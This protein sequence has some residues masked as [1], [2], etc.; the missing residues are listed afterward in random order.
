MILPIQMLLNRSLMLKKISTAL[1]RVTETANSIVSRLADIYVDDLDY[2]LSL[3]GYEEYQQVDRETRQ[4]LA[5]L[6]G[7]RTNF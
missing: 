7:T 2:Y 4:G 1:R 6:A 5:V 3:K